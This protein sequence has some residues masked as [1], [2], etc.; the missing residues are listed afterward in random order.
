[1]L[2]DI[3][4]YKNR[5][6]QAQKPNPWE[7]GNS[8]LYKLCDEYPKHEKLEIIIAKIW[9]IG[10]SYAAAIERGRNNSREIK[11]DV[12]YTEK[13]GPEL[14]ESNIDEIISGL[15]KE[16]KIEK[17]NIPDILIAHKYLIELFKDIK[18]SDI[19]KSA[20]RHDRS[21][22]SKYLHFHLCNLFFIYDKL[23]LNALGK[24]IGK[25][26][27]Q[28]PYHIVL[29]ENNIDKDYSKF[30]IKCLMLR[31]KISNELNINLTPRQLDNFLIDIANNGI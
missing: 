16:R 7:F 2:L 26:S 6:L 11:N 18:K 21:L 10:R 23:A 12:F 4:N 5:I 19:E 8:I 3:K 1:M 30:F 31:D 24:F 9:L 13:V 28:N 25:I 29:S 20:E 15:Q 14:Q 22:S 17:K 27:K